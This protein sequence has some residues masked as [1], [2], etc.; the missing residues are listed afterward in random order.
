MI[1]VRLTSGLGNQLFQY[2]AA[3]ALSLRLDRPLKF[4]A[5]WYRD[6][7]D[8]KAKRVYELGRFNV[9][10]AFAT[11]REIKGARGRTLSA[12]I[13]RRVLGRDLERAYRR[14]EDRETLLDTEGLRGASGIYLNGFWQSEDFFKDNA[15]LIRTEFTLKAAPNAD[16]LTWLEKIEG[17]ES[18]CIH[19]RRG[20]YVRDPKITEAHGICSL[21][22]YRAAIER[23]NK[24]AASPRF[25][26]F[27]DDPDWVRD[28]LKIDGPAEYVVH[29]GGDGVED[30]RLMSRCRYFVI[31][32]S[33]FSWWAAWLSGRPKMVFAP[34]PWF[35]DPS[36]SDH[37]PALPGWIRLPA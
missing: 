1:I 24:E 2:A 7:P 27:S 32:N 36:R 12:R 3:R 14:V 8:R 31:A 26:V 23:I 15:D 9:V 5:S 19:V 22:Y 25:F 18:V 4:D 21:D 33:T 34:S 29:N 17:A 37:D 13:A 20:D 10:E 28:N 11:D 35:K 30:L 6:I 16:N